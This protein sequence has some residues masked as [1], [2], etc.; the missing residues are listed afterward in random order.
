MKT[1]VF[2]PTTARQVRLRTTRATNG[3]GYASAAEINLYGS[4][5]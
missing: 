5:A 4:T 3:A 1:A 2:T